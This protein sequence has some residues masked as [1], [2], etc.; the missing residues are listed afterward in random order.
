[1]RRR[2]ILTIF[3]VITSVF[4]WWFWRNR[5]L[6]VERIRIAKM[7][8]NVLG[9]F[10]TDLD[11]D[12]EVESLLTY[13]A[14][15]HA[16]SEQDRRIH[17]ASMRLIRSPLGNSK[18]V[19]LPFVCR[20][21]IQ[22][23]TTPV[24]KVPIAKGWLQLRN[25]QTVIEPFV[26]P[27]EGVATD[28]AIW[29]IDRDGMSDDV[30]ITVRRNNCTE[31]RGF[32]LG[33][34]GEWQLFWR[35]RDLPPAYGSRIG[36]FDDDGFWETV[37]CDRKNKTVTVRWGDTNLIT[38]LILPNITEMK[39]ADLDSDG[40]DELLVLD[41][42]RANRR[43]TIW[44]ADA[45]R[46]MRCVTTSPQI[47][48]PRTTHFVR[49]QL[50]LADWNDDGRKEI[51][52][53][54]TEYRPG[55]PP[56][57]CIFQLGA[58]SWDG[59]RLQSYSFRNT[60][61]QSDWR[62]L[63]GAFSFNGKRHVAKTVPKRLGRFYPRLLSL[64]P[65]RIQWWQSEDHILG[66]ICRLPDKDDVFDMQRWR[67]VATLPAAPVHIGDFDDDGQVEM[68]LQDRLG[69]SNWL[70]LA[71]F[72]GRRVQW[73]KW[74]QPDEERTSVM[75][76]AAAHISPIKYKTKF[77]PSPRRTVALRDNNLTAI[78]VAW[79]NGVIERVRW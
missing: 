13:G 11:S 76:V 15:P 29:D 58:F 42:S 4:A 72:D 32:K 66:E 25:G 57:T 71:Q 18:V 74:K 2:K 27:S 31:K 61:R 78:F 68:V 69:A 7:S 77:H 79:D 53:T 46:Q 65:L 16:F 6:S 33:D 10:V 17:S 45:T 8:P 1:M 40:Q 56:P 50:R 48:M 67:L 63:E 37:A 62:K 60:Q 70:Y 21:E 19:K 59:K 55:S 12:G 34:D 3:V 64:N 73:T 35:R 26:S 36:D 52:V 51:E 14:S 22:H 49:W 39:I 28:F 43:L 20:L 54:C 41:A 38:T 5:P 9:L 44:R 30:V 47:S 24:R 75:Y 23:T